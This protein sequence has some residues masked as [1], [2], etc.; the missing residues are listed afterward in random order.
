MTM[1]LTV[2]K[3]VGRRVLAELD[4]QPIKATVLPS[5]GALGRQTEYR[6]A[7][8][9]MGGQEFNIIATQREWH[10][11]WAA[12]RAVFMQGEL[13]LP[14]TPRD[15]DRFKRGDPGHPDNDMGM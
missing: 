3:K 12:L 9:D 2:H 14:D 6:L 11:A 7:L 13:G 8:H 4:T 5:S 10:T 15:E 1:R